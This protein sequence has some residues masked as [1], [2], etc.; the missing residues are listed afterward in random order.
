M[1]PLQKKIIRFITLQGPIDISQYMLMT[2][3]DPEYGYYK[4]VEPFG[5]NGDFI[6]APE[7][8]QMFGEMIAIWAFF[9]WQGMGQP[10]PFLFCE[11]GPGRGTL[12]DDILRTVGKIAPKCLAAARIILIETSERLAISQK[13]K[14]RLYDKKIEWIAD[15]DAIPNFPLIL[16]A[17]EL[18]DAL[19][20]HQYML[21]SHGILYERMIAFD[22]ALNLCFAQSFANPHLP[23]VP[24]LSKKFP[25]ETIIEISPERVALVESISTHI[26]R[27]RGA[28]L[29]IDYGALEP[30]FG[31]TLQ[32]ISQH[33]F[34]SPL[35]NPGTCDL[36]SHVDFFALSHAARKK[37]CHTA[38][39]TQGDFL[40][41]LGL[42]ERASRL[43]INKNEADRQKIANDV[44][45]LCA[46][47]Q[48]GNLFKVLCIADT[49]TSMQP[50]SWVKAGLNQER[51]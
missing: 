20:I 27:K 41:K 4:T 38:E 6:T 33:T 10:S 51:N 40:I 23:F 39:L 44:E 37:G 11:I 50:F 7:I 1:S 32:A 29:I 13:K 21:T 26:A 5:G 3:A 19:P 31:D 24:I 14:L 16:I 42:F 45:R 2:L 12:M 46:H 25:D 18:F 49:K 17:N 36:T 28:A 15:I 22:K 47:N 30:S 34:C 43:S 35:E 8:S 48:M 9:A